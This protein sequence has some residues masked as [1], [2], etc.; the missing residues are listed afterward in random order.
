MVIVVSNLAAER[1]VLTA[2]CSGRGWPCAECDSVRSARKALIRLRPSVV[3]VRHRLADGYSDDVIGLLKTLDSTSSVRVMVLATAGLPAPI[4]AR[5]IT[6]GAEVVYRDPIRIEVILAQVERYRA[7]HRHPA[8]SRS[9]ASAKSVEFAGARV[10]LL[11][12]TL[13]YRGRSIGLTPKEVELVRVLAD[14]S[15]E[16]ATY[17]QLYSEILGRTFRGDTS[18]M[19]VLLGKLA[20]SLRDVKLDLRAVVEVIPKSG[21]RYRASVGD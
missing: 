14:A 21:Y 2:A 4:E 16:V 17:E 13:S 18:N 10:D 19:R 5:Q 20:A 11:Q 6:L 7:L 3:I 8:A 9:A 12:H 1:L 15:G